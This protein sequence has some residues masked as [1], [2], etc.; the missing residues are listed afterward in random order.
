ME[1]KYYVLTGLA[2]GLGLIGGSL[3]PSLTTNPA[4]KD[5]DDIVVSIPFNTTDIGVNEIPDAPL[6]SESQVPAN[7]CSRYVRFAARDLYDI[8]YPADDAWKLR[9]HSNMN[10]IKLNSGDDLREL[11]DNETLKPGMVVGMFYPASKYN[12]RQDVEK[13]GYTHVLLY[14]GS[15][16]GELYFADKFGSKIRKSSLSKLQSENGL[17]PKEILHKKN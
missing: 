10:A 5:L 9:N 7:Y 3:V 4:K 14:L 1:R 15:K 16:D 17:V 2:L 8:E 6:Y 12:G 13:A 11:A